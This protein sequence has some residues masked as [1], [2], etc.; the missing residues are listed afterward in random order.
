MGLHGLPQIPMY[1]YNSVKDT[2]APIVDDDALVTKYCN[3][4]IK[5]LVH[6]RN[7]FAGHISN[8]VLGYSGAM[9]FVLDRFDGEPAPEGCHIKNVHITWPDLEDFKE[10]SAEVFATIEELIGQRL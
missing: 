4:G 6:K 2:I 1:F 7:T 3:M 5:S 10:F 9:K 8:Y